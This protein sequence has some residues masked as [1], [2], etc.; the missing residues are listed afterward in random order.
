MYALFSEWDPVGAVK[1]LGCVRPDSVVKIN[2]LGQPGK[3]AWH[4]AHQ[5]AAT[6]V[7]LPKQRGMTLP[8]WRWGLEIIINQK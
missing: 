8:G 6:A 1:E 5:G 3:L 2:M 4:Q 7:L